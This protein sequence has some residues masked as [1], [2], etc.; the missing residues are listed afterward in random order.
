MMHDFK[1]YL[2]RFLKLRS[3]GNTS[4]DLFSQ[5]VLQPTALKSPCQLISNI[6]HPPSLTDYSHVI[7]NSTLS[8]SVGKA[9]F[10]Y[11]INFSQVPLMGD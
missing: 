6:P 9:P 3:A 7:N 2:S 10:T 8:R 1:F 4:L 5:S 11:L